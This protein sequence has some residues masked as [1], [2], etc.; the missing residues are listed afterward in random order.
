MKEWAPY[1]GA[2]RTKPNH[3]E[4]RKE[5]WYIGHYS[6]ISTRDLSVGSNNK[7]LISLTAFTVLSVHVLAHL[8]YP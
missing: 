2:H 6:Q 3:K 8:K 1:S 4:T 7:I 5:A